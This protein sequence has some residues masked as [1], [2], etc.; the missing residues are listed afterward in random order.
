MKNPFA[1]LNGNNARGGPGRATTAM[2]S[3]NSNTINNGSSGDNENPIVGFAKNLVR[4][5]G[6]IG[7]R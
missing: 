2:R 4:G 6:D 7:N 1:G 5:I 3:S